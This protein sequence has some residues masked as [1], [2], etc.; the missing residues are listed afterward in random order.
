[1]IYCVTPAQ[2]NVFLSNLETLPVSVEYRLRNAVRKRREVWF[3]AN[4]LHRVLLAA[5]EQQQYDPA[6]E[7]HAAILGAMEAIKGARA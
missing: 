4:E 2:A 1:M 7:A 6:D 5:E 3:N